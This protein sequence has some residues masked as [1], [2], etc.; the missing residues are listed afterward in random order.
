MAGIIETANNAYEARDRANNEIETLKDQAKREAEDFQNELKDLA[1][2]AETNRKAREFA[3][4][5]HDNKG[6]DINARDAMDIEK[7]HKAKN[8]KLFKETTID[9]NLKEEHEK[10]QMEFS[11]IESATHVKD[12]EILIKNFVQM[13]ED[14]FDIYKFIVDLS[15]TVETLEAQIKEYRDEKKRYEGT[16]STL[17]VKKSK[18][19]KNLDN[20][21]LNSRNKTEYYSTKCSNAQKTLNSVKKLIQT[22]AG[23]VMCDTSQ[24]TNINPNE[25]V[26]ESNILA[27]MSLIE[28]R[29]VEVVHAYNIIRVHVVF[30]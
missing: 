24:S 6:D 26:T 30:I 21:S 29:L 22:L 25:G 11:K 27:F 13:E 28:D 15:N 10:L 3:N 9:P 14:N 18:Y 5:A 16:G 20:E 1:Q 2:L 19:L 4:L 17:A 7:S 8:Q 23:T 12:F